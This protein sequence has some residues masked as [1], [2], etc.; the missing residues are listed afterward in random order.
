MQRNPDMQFLFETFLISR[1]IC[2][3]SRKIKKGDIFFALK[4]PNFD[5]NEYIKSALNQGAVLAVSDSVLYQDHDNVVVFQNSLSAL[6]DLARLYRK[7]LNCKVIGLTGSNGKT[8]TKELIYRVM[9]SHYDTFCTLGNLNNHIGVPLTILSTPENIDYLIVEM[10]ANAQG[11]IKFLSELASPDFGLITNIG[12]AHLEGF[13]GIDGVIKGKTELYRFLEESGGKVFINMEDP[14]L[15]N[16]IPRNIYA[17]EYVDYRIIKMDKSIKIEVDDVFY[18]SPLY[19]KYNIDNIVAAITIGLYFKVPSEKIQKAVAEYNPDNNRSSVKK[20]G[21]HK[22]FFDAYNANPSSVISSLAGF[23]HATENNRIVILGDM[24]ELGPE[25][26]LEHIK[27]TEIVK[28]MNFDHVFYIGEI[29][30][31]LDIKNSFLSVAEFKKVIDI[32]DFSP[33]NILIKGSRKIRL[34]NLFLP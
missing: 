3:D 4:G 19:G 2:T 34:E 32:E 12:K 5:G 6:Q 1:S 30:K 7:H 21:K 10:G 31:S 33:S 22:V 20:I 25:S 9:S 23:I 11:E 26:E 14:V 8:T 29:Y 13:G 27:V 16:H 28:E 17:I 24:L 18:E 15:V